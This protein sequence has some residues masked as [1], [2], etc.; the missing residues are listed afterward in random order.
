MTALKVTCALIILN[1]KVLVV[2]NNA[3]S[4]HAFKWEFAG[5]KIRV[6]E[7]EEDAIKREINEELEIEIDI[8]QKINRVDFDYDFK[9]IVLIPFLCSIKKGELKL[10]EHK[11]FK[12]VN[13]TELY[14]IDFS[15][16]DKKLIKQ[17]QNLAI[18]KEYIGK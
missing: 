7:T 14:E 8:L 4:D 13:Y 9:Q 17:K 1:K 11:D 18:L 5:G 2:Q 15:G 12:W 16:A 3:N 10:N 6:N